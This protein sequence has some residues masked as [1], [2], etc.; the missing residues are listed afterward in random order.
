M[1]K[2]FLLLLFLF[3]AGYSVGP[4]FVL[5]MKRDGAEA[6]VDRHCRELHRSCG[7]DRRGAQCCDSDPG[8]AAGLM[9]GALSQSAAMGT[10]TDAVNGLA[11]SEAQRTVFVSHIAVADA[12]GYTFGA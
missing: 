4:Q 8:L 9:S 6:D 1:T 5:A 12:V 11:V 2:S 3:G 10:A 7:G